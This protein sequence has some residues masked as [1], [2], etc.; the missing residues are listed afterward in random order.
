MLLSDVIFQGEK[1]FDK[2]SG[3]C[4]TPSVEVKGADS[5]NGSDP[6]LMTCSVAR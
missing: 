2:I 6:N 1:H 4:C 3:S 5:L